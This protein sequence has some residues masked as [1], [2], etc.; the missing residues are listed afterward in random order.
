[1]DLAVD[2]V[3]TQ[4]EWDYR[5]GDLQ[6][7]WTFTGV[8]N[9][10]RIGDLVKAWSMNMAEPVKVVGINPEDIEVT[11]SG[12]EAG[13]PV[14][15]T[16]SDQVHFA[17]LAPGTIPD[18]TTEWKEATWAPVDQPGNLPDLYKAICTVSGLTPGRYTI[19]VRVTHGEKQPTEEVGTLIVR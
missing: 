14:D 5:F 2:Y 12:T 10:W 6:R 8:K 4:R 3:P 18:L 17:F 7:S 15:P 19:W 11:I 9:S 13:E 1:M 16:L